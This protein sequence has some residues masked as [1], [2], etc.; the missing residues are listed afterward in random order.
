VTWTAEIEVVVPF[1]DLDPMSIVW[2]GNYAKY[3]E[4][5]RS[6]LLQSIRYDCDEMA[7]S[8][9]AWPVVE[10]HIRYPRPLKYQQV[11]RVTAS[12]AEYENRLKIRYEIRDVADG[13]RLTHGHTVQ[14]AVRM[15]E[16]E[17]CMVSPPILFE[18]LGRTAP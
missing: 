9:Y 8:G 17:M 12:I 5:A 1:H 16:A 15:P 6:R 4:I 14:I 10:L 13:R 11:V 7:R 18:K 3:F 2:H